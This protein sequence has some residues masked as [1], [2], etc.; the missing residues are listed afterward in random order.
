MCF[1]T[2][3][4]LMIETAIES[5][6]FIRNARYHCK[7]AGWGDGA[8]LKMSLVESGNLLESALKVCASRSNTADVT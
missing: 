2:A 3:Y 6:D 7:I 4:V 5:Y 8:N 1:L